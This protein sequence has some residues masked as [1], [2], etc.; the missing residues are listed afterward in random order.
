VRLAAVEKLTDEA[1]LADIAKSDGNRTVC[2]AAVAGISDQTLLA[3][4]S[5]S[6]IDRVVCLVAV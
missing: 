3:S 1:T 2:K 4:V 5:K 6:L